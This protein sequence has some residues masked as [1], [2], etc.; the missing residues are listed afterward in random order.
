CPVKCFD[1]FQKSANRKYLS[2]AIFVT[3]YTLIPSNPEEPN[4]G[5]NAQPLLSD[6][7]NINFVNIF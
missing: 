2:P 3:H 7:R 1:L 4:S 6:F 5:A